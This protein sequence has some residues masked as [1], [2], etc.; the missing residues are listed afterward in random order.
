MKK[1]PTRL[2]ALKI[3]E[4]SLVDSPANRG[5]RVI[6]AKREDTMFKPCADCKSVEKCSEMQK[7]S[8]GM[9]K[10]AESGFVPLLRRMA[11]HLGIDPNHTDDDSS[12]S[13]EESVH[14]DYSKLSADELRAELAKRDVVAGGTPLVERLQKAE[15]DLIATNA[16]LAKAE[17]DAAASAAKVEKLNAAAAE[18]HVVVLAKSMV[19]NAVVELSDVTTI[20]KQVDEAGSKA[21]ESILK[22]YSGIVEEAELF[23]PVG[24]RADDAGETS[25]H[26]KLHKR[27]VEIAKRD[28]ITYE[29]AVVEAM[30]E[31]PDAYEASLN[32]NVG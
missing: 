14:K 6:L 30:D 15:T 26:S 22:K 25:A 4:L 8:G 23:E 29:A 11:K 2:T 12:D 18:R 28:S 24:K 27:A 17:S 1:K 9:M 19:G 31:D 20:L 3:E 16:R 10:S 13:S 5:S 21:L 32:E 7:C